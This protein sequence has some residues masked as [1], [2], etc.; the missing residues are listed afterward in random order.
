MFFTITFIL[1]LHHRCSF[2]EEKKIL[3]RALSPVLGIEALRAKQHEKMSA[4]ISKSQMIG[5][6]HFWME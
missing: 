4:T 3:Y 5:P 1:F 2:I 6:L